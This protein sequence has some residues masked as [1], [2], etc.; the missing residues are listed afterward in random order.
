MNSLSGVAWALQLR[1]VSHLA[2]LCAICIGDRGQDQNGF[3]VVPIR[4]LIDFVEADY[5]NVLVALDELR[6]A[7][8]TWADN[9]AG[10]F[11]C[12]IPDL[13]PRPQ[14]AREPSESRMAIY[15]FSS[16]SV[17][18][19]GISGDPAGRMAN[20][21][22]ARPFEP[23]RSHFVHHGPASVIR[24]AEKLAHARLADRLISNEWFN[25]SPDECIA[26][27]NAALVEASDVKSRRRK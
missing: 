24:R 7:G 23:V 26:A 27:V 3:H 6:A 1:G 19:I 22:A 13:D 8:L 2:R 20:L 16:G 15:V 4:A 9:G 11:A 12:R 5:D 17:S 25:A 18:K 21:H 10:A 14:P